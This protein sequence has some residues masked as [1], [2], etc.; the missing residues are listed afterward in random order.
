MPTLSGRAGRRRS[1]PVHI[2][3]ALATDRLMALIAADPAKYGFLRDQIETPEFT[4]HVIW[5]L[6]TDPAPAERS[7][8]TVIGAQMAEN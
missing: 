6:Y 4:G 8:Q 3:S 5:A 2:H 1:N 7:G